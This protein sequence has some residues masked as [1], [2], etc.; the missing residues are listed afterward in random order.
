M[1]CPRWIAGVTEDDLCIYRDMVKV[2][3]KQEYMQRPI[4]LPQVDK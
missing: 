2:M 4:M 1:Y 3:M